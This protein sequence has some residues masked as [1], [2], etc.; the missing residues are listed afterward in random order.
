[1]KPI[2]SFKILFYIAVLILFTGITSCSRNNNTT[3]WAYFPDMAYSWAYETYSPNPNLPG[4]YT[5]QS[6]VEGTIPREM[7]PYQYKKTF[8]DQQRAGKELINPFQPTVENITRGKQEY[9][10]YCIMCHGADGAGDGYLYTSKLFPAKP[11]ALNRE[12]VQNKP[13]G[14]IFHVITLGSLSGLMGAH[15]SQIKPDDRWKI[16]LYIRSAFGTK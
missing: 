15:G 10:T 13:D 9:E 2:Y 3:D 1:M 12:F 16:V 8:E 5:E 6:P 14:E 11:M 7:I 4:G